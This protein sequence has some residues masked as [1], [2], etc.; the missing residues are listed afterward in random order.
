[1]SGLYCFYCIYYNKFAKLPIN[2]KQINQLYGRVFSL[3]A[4]PVRSLCR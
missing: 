1:M 2:F 4:H 3:I